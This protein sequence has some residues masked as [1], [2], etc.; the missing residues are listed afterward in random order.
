MNPLPLFAL[1]VS[2]TLLAPAQAER[3]DRSKPLSIEADQ[4]GTVDLLK[5]VVVFNG[6]VV[7]AQGT[8][9]IRAERVEVRERPDGHRSA[10]AL[11]SAGKPA[12]FRQKRDGVDETIEGSADRIEYDSRGDVVRFTGNAQVRRLRGAAPADEVTGN[13]ITYDNGNETFSVQGAATAPGVGGAPGSGRVRVVIT[14]KPEATGTPAAE[15]KR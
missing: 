2:A 5:Q 14:P 6:N 3:A 11:G 10:T 15:P 8:M 9:A 13:V 7:V 12:A 1:L 4:P